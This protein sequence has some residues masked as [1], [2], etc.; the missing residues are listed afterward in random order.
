MPDSLVQHAA[1]TVDGLLEEAMSHYRARR[2][3]E[4]EALARQA[5]ALRPGDAKIWNM[6]GIFQR[7]RGQSDAAI[8][9]F[10]EAL[11]IAP[12]SPGAWSNLGHA[13]KD[14]KHIESAIACQRHA[15]TLITT[16]ASHFHDLGVALTAAGRHRE[17]LDAFDRALWLNPSD[18]LLRW[19]RG[20]AHLH[21]GDFA[22]GWP[23]YESRLET[24]HLLKRDLPGQRWRGE[25][26]RGQSL[27]VVS[28]QGF[29]DTIW[30]ARY[31]ASVK[32]SGCTLSLECHA[33]LIPLIEPLGI[34]DRIV[35]R[36]GALPDADWHVHICSLPGLFTPTPA[37]I[38]PTPYLSIPP[39]R[40]DKFAPVMAQAGGRLK[41]GIVWSGSTAFAA[42]GDRAVGLERFVRAFSLPGVQLYSLQ[43]G[44]PA[45][46]LKAYPDARI[47]DLD[48]LI[49]DFVDTA[50][51]LD[52]LDLV[53]MTD[54]AVAHLGGA[55]GRPVWVLLNFV[56]Y[57]LWQSTRSTC[58]WYPSLRLFR[59]KLWNDWDGVF[60]AAAAA[61]LAQ[62]R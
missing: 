12:D 16:D 40:A 46:E 7:R 29:G 42:N 36:G 14:C 51:I 22:A 41:V 54:S 44:A 8:A 50:S 33:E 60:D 47:I 38:P 3:V 31:L 28:E 58:P 45:A 57:W 56:P 21:L 37:A 1:E 19:D 26:C 23:D 32:A 2:Y 30:A 35:L 15:L 4:A 39:G 59:P 20:L 25:A 24:G 62:R 17:A 27:L 13:L 53:I 43:K 61:L 49:T 34:V 18:P 9:S 52:R 55:L 6:R 10:R 11:E 5:L 48:G